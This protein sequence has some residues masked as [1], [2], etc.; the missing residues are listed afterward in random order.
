M[1][2]MQG[3]EM[4]D[5]NCPITPPPELVKQWCYEDRDEVATSPRWFHIVCTKAARWGADQELE[6]CCEHIAGPGKWFAN[7]Q[8]RLDELR[9]ARRPKPPSLKEQS[10]KH[11]EVMERDGHYL[12]EI[13]SDLRRAIESLPS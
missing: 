11:L 7:P 8:F 6:A 12:P 4:T 1:T 5:N 10:L 3:F 13:I 9:A 2:L